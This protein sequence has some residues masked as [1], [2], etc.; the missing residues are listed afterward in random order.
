[1]NK[2]LQMFRLS[3]LHGLF[4]TRKSRDEGSKKKNTEKKKEKKKTQENRHKIAIEW[5]VLNPKGGS[6]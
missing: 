5:E 6:F 4:K 3:L 1:M 2:G